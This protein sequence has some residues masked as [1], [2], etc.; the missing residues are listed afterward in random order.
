[1]GLEVNAGTDDIID[2]EH[3]AIKIEDDS[4]KM[5]WG[6][7]LN[8]ELKESEKTRSRRLRIEVNSK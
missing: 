8:A 7:F 1:V 5:S 2:G 3:D 6:C 4:Y